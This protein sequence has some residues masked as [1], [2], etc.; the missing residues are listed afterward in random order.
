MD[1][2]PIGFS[3][4]A[5]YPQFILYARS[6]D[7]DTG[8]IKKTPVHYHTLKICN[9]QDPENHASFYTARD[10]LKKA[11]RSKPESI[12]Y[13]IG[14]VLMPHDPFFCLDIDHAFDPVTQKW[15]DLSI[16]LRTR[17]PQAAV[18]IS[19]SKRG[20]HI[21]GTLSEPLVHRCT[22]PD[23]LG[24]DLYT[25]KRFI[26]LTGYNAEGDIST[27]CTA[28]LRG[29]IA[30]YFKVEEPLELSTWTD[31]PCEGWRGHDNDADLIRHAC[32]R[33]SARASFGHAPDFSSLWNRN[34]DTLKHYYPSKATNRAFDDSAADLALAAHLA[35][36]TGNNCDRI[37][38]L[39]LRSSLIREK[40]LKRPD[41]LRTTILKAC[42]QQQQVSVVTT[43]PAVIDTLPALQ[44]VTTLP[45]AQHDLTTLQP[46]PKSNAGVFLGAE[47]QINYFKGCVYIQRLHAVYT[48]EGDILNPE[49]FKVRYGG[50]VYM[51]DHAGEK[52]TIDAWKAFTQCQMV[53]F[54]K[55]YRGVFLPSRPPGEI[56]EQ[57]GKLVVNTYYPIKTRCIAGDATPFLTHIAKLLPDETDQTILISYLAACVQYPGVKF[58]W[59]PI[60]QGVEG[61]GKTLISRCIAEC[62]G[63][64]YTHSPRAQAIAARFNSWMYRKLFAWVDE[65][66]IEETNQEAIDS[67]KIILSED[68]IELEPKGVD[69]FFEEICLNFVLNTN[70]KHA[71]KKTDSERRLAIFFTAQQTHADLERSGLTEQYFYDLVEGWLKKDGYAIV[72]HYLLNYKIPDQYNPATL[73]V[74]APITSTTHE[75]INATQ[76]PYEIE[77]KD[78]IVDQLPGFRGDFISSVLLEKLLEK[79]FLHKMLPRRARKDFLNRM[80]YVIHPLLDLT[81]HRTPRPVMPDGSRTTLYV[82]KKSNLLDIESIDELL[83][84]YSKLN[85]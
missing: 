38:R 32:S 64:Q 13:G 28:A 84:T 57:E 73:C 7:R 47:G 48:P 70:F 50:H 25:S 21:L 52:S 42:A 3:A 77:I 18:E 54:P 85:S 23:G 46:V 67:L 14:F 66:L 69:A 62:V 31:T 51:L 15:S 79:A 45:V 36:H 44:T 65:I 43:L 35:Y 74:R 2:L 72:H 71:I 22:S 20:L 55:V 80:G 39:M 68:R 5:D 8:K 16:D 49:Q 81:S 53:N 78:A 37:Y 76:S 10:A 41:Y 12:E 75:A 24:L 56:M 82:K 4:L 59:C 30:T 83:D 6:Q 9:A 58:R 27:D 40:W 26:A 61:N 63:Y 17:L 11:Q 29:I 33:K 19:T 1:V 34:V 60:L